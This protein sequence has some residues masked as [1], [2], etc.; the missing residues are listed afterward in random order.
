MK[1]TLVALPSGIEPLS[2]PYLR[3][4]LDRRSTCSAYSK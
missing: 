4:H 3:I 1:K 2:V